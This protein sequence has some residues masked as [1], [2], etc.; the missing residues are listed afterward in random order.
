MPRL[1][2]GLAKRQLHDLFR[3][4]P[5]VHRDDPRLIR[6]D[7]QKIE[8]EAIAPVPLF[9]IYIAID[10]DLGATGCTDLPSS[11]KSTKNGPPKTRPI[12][13]GNARMADHPKSEFPDL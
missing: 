6:I 9:D 2:S 10:P 12:S 5:A 3:R 11:S 4:C 7:A 1:A 8:A 13:S